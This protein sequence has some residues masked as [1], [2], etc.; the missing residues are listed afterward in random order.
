[1]TTPAIAPSTPSALRVPWVA[2]AWEACDCG[3]YWCTVH[4]QHAHECPCPPVDEWPTDPYSDP[5][6]HPAAPT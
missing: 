1:M 2:P 5:T 4:Q 6:P 3:D